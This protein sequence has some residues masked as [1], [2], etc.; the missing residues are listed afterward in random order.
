MKW[1]LA[2]CMMALTGCAA[3][4]TPQQKVFAATQNYN[5]ALTAAVTYKRLPPCATPKTPG[6]ICSEKAVIAVV[7]KADT[8]AYEALTSAQRVVRDPNQPATLL[9]TAVVWAQ[10]AIAAFT[11]VLGE[12]NVK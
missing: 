12:L 9:A 4:D 11:R 2:V 5:V 6:V 3:L 8:V 1:I 10:E 7:Q